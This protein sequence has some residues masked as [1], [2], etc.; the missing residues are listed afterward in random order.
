VALSFQDFA[1]QLSRCAQSDE[2]AV[3]FMEA[4]AR[5]RLE[6]ITK[7]LTA[8]LDAVAAETEEL[9]APDWSDN[10]LLAES[11]IR[12]DDLA[13]VNDPEK[14]YLHIE[15]AVA[16]RKSVISVFLDMTGLSDKQRGD[17][18]PLLST[19]RREAE[20]S[21]IAREVQRLNRHLDW[22]RSRG[23]QPEAFLAYHRN[24]GIHGAS[25]N[26]GGAVGGMGAALAFMDALDEISPGCIDTINGAP[27]FAPPGRSPEEI[28]EYLFAGSE[29]EREAKR[30]RILALTN[31]R[32][33]VFSS[34]PDV[35][36]FMPLSLPMS[37]T[38]ASK[39]KG[40]PKV[41][42]YTSSAEAALALYN[43]VRQQ[44][45]ARRQS[46]HEFAVGEVKTATDPS[47]LHE[48]LALGSRE[49]KIEVNC[50]R[51]LLM[52]LLTKDLIE[53]GSGKR[54]GRTPLQNRDTV[55]F[56]DVFNLHFAWGWD[57]ARKRHPEH[58]EA[59]KA[60]LKDWCGL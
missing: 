54:S 33:V 19:E 49:T 60:R 48:R 31:G 22:I 27:P 8:P 17:L 14:R 2:E 58:W 1:D 21:A 25:Q 39:G 29:K 42:T 59:F 24:L 28:A 36:I 32:F 40:R 47:N 15:V 38:S 44:S 20:R 56:S 9:I 46:L 35:S 10:D 52:A 6:V 51:F 45:A 50:D 57:G 4:F 26:A 34:D 3:A 5:V 23:V 53:G 12:R 41:V 37:A 16:R 13:G 30:I 18:F 43:K 55:R 11:G 7:A